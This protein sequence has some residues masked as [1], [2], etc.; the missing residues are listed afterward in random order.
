MKSTVEMSASANI[1]HP[2]VVTRLL[3]LRPLPLRHSTF[4]VVTSNEIYEN[5]GSSLLI[6]EGKKIY[7]NNLVYL[8]NLQPQ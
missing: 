8:S 1:S 4:F 2:P 7:R 3:T 5:E 6:V